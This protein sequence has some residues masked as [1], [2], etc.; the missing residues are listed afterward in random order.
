MTTVAYLSLDLS[1]IDSQDPSNYNTCRS[2]DYN[3]EV[4][5]TEIE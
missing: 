5:M 1:K 3:N 4:K 2:W